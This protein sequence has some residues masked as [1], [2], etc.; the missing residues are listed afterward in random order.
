MDFSAPAK[1]FFVPFLVY[2]RNACAENAWSS[3]YAPGL[4]SAWFF[5]FLVFEAGKE[6][7]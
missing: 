3:L 6:Y 7:L 5:I 1:I 4:K 2:K